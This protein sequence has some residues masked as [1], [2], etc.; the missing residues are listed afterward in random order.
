M[1]KFSQITDRSV[2]KTAATC[3]T[4][5]EKAFFVCF[6]YATLYFLYNGKGKK[7]FIIRFRPIYHE[8]CKFEMFFL[9]K[10]IPGN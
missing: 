9:H 7:G 10:R 2:V 3:I 4:P 6:L 8:T 5:V 1:K